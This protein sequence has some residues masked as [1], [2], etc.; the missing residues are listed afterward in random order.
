MSSNYT[1]ADKADAKQLFTFVNQKQGR[2]HSEG[3][4]Q[5]RYSDASFCTDGANP[6]HFERYL[7]GKRIGQGAYAV[8]RAGIDTQ[9]NKKVAIKI[10]EKVNLLDAQRRKGVRREIKLLERM[11]HENIV[12]LFEAFDNKTA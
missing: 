4:N 2:E 7:I 8:V 11:N 3:T 6:S 10:Y 1:K 12:H 9:T 5:F